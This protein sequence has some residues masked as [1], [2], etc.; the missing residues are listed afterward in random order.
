[1]K[2][3]GTVVAVGPYS[4]GTDVDSWKDITAVATGG[5]HT[6]GLKSDGTVVATGL[7]QYGQTNVSGWRNIIAIAAG[8]DH[9]VGLRSDGTVVAVGKNDHGELNVSGWKDVQSISAGLQSTKGYKKNGVIL[10]T[11]GKF[12]TKDELIKPQLRINKKTYKPNDEIIITLSKGNFY[13]ISHPTITF[14]GGISL[15]DAE[16]T[17]LPNGDFEYRYI[18]NATEI[19]KVNLSISGVEDP[20][21]NNL[22]ADGLFSII[23]VQSIKSSKT[24][25][26]SGEKVTLTATFNEGVKPDFKLS[27]SGATTLSATKMTEVAGS[28]G[29]K[30]MFTYTVPYNYKEGPVD[31]T[32]TNVETV[33]GQIFNRF[34]DENVFLK[35]NRLA[36][37]S[38]IT[39]SENKAKIGDTVTITANFSESVK[40]GV[41]ISFDGADNMA[42]V[43][44]NQTAGSNGMQ[45]M[46]NYIVP[47][48][49]TGKMNAHI[50]EVYDLNNK[51]SQEYVSKNLFEIDGIRPTISSLSPSLTAAKLGDKVVIRAV[52]DEPVKPDFMLS[53]YGDVD[54]RDLSMQ[55]V[56]GS[57]STVYEYSYLV[58][59]GDLGFVSAQIRNVEDLV[60]NPYGVY[61]SDVYNKLNIFQADGVSP[62]LSSL[63]PEDKEYEVGDYAHITASFT[64][65]VKPGV[66]ITLS[67]GVNHEEYVMSEVQGSNGKEYELYYEVKEGQKGIVN[68]LLTNVIDLAGN[69]VTAAKE[70]VF[71]ISDPSNANLATISVTDGATRYSLT[72]EFSAG[73]DTYS[74]YLPSHVTS[75]WVNGETEDSKATIEGNGLKNLVQG[76]NSFILK[77]TSSNLSTKFYKVIINVA[78]D[79]KPIISGVKDQTIGLDT[80]FD[81]VDGVEAW[82][83]VDGNITSLMKVEGS[84]NIHKPGNYDLVYTVTDQAGNHAAVYRRVTVVDNIA[85][86][87]PEVNPI[88]D[89]Q[90]VI[91]GKAEPNATVVAK[92]YG[93]SIGWA[94][95]AEDG[96]FT[97]AINKQNAG[98]EI[99]VHAVDMYGNPGEATRVVVKDVT[100]PGNPVI[101]DV[102]DKDTIITGNAEPGSKLD[103]KVNDVIIGTGT[104]GESGQYSVTIPVQKAGT[105]IAIIAIDQAGNVSKTTKVVVKDITSPEKPVANEVTDKDTSVTG[106]AE[107][108]SKVEV[109]VNDSVIGAGTAG[110]DGQFKVTFDLQKAGT[111][112]EV[113]VTDSAG[114][115]SETTTVVVKDITSPA[116]PGVNEVTDKD[117][118]VT[119][120][121]EAGSKVEVKV[122]GSVIGT[123]TAGEDGQYKMTIDVQKAGTELVIVATDKAGNVSEITTVVVRDATAPGLP[124]VNEVTD[125]DTSVTG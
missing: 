105:E 14:S 55:E 119:G 63:E 7:N 89:N 125:K 52:F 25:T 59:E 20:F 94:Q 17:P 92:A 79:T 32:L 107:A 69:E 51:L 66:K 6:V 5:Y 49:Y 110:E 24:V 58:K 33:N 71:Y 122:N 98:T 60:G 50:T 97:I 100:A 112:L 15:V 85:P 75:V 28:N 43:Y 120:Q 72:P 117:T 16:M 56:E 102:T 2:K 8:A 86:L 30:Y 64:E 9:T 1:L 106:L 45:Y 91:N 4:Y 10:T 65:P 62:A 57:N 103:V 13:N 87:A 74:T 31:A 90:L 22:Q 118:A 124:E 39:S 101:N 41:K 34:T 121:V 81:P 88:G 83:N 109:K 29:T 11:D 123:G 21:G 53:L 116:K 12:Y 40:S 19:G 77:V 36:P 104:V 47:E 70:K 80:S 115:V 54:I 78:D 61:N 99:S 46:Y 73:I 38:S 114:N 67:G 108:G 3:D 44:M 68:G 27:L 23:P 96:S 37:I 113:V 84:V 82:D 93:S 42:P 18:P 26:S 35:Q 95:V 76:E 111:N 48:G